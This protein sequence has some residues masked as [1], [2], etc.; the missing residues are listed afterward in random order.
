M[1]LLV[2]GLFLGITSTV[3]SVSAY[4]A[5]GRGG[6]SFILAGVSANASYIFH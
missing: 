5:A 4:A 6:G 1:K 3:F 2:W